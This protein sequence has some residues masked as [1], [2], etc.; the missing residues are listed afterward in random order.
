MMAKAKQHIA[1]KWITIEVFCQTYSVSRQVAYE[2]IRNGEIESVLLRGTMRR[3]N[4]A[5][6]DRFFAAMIKTL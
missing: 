5:S 3:I 4:A 6:A 2:L 1:P